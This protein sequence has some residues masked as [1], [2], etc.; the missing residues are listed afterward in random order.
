MADDAPDPTLD[1]L[2]QA[3][4]DGSLS[5]ANIR[6]LYRA[7]QWGGL[8]SHLPNIQPAWMKTAQRY[9]GQGLE[10]AQ[11]YSPEA[12]FLSNFLTHNPALAGTI[13]PFPGPR[14]LAPIKAAG[15]LSSQRPTAMSPSEPTFLPTREPPQELSPTN[16]PP[17]HE[18]IGKGSSGADVYQQKTTLDD[19]MNNRPRI[20]PYSKEFRDMRRQDFNTMYGALDV[21]LLRQ[22]LE[23]VQ[24]MQGQLRAG[25]LPIGDARERQ[26]AEHHLQDRIDSIM[27]AIRN[28]TF[29][30]IPGGKE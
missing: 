21:P 13:I 12:T 29:R 24:Q 17:G 30:S 7:P 10:G 1:M 2:R 14:P 27:G 15:S 5:T 18:Y 26:F 6:D 23:E 8:A 11:N 9:F 3:Y 20:D 16:P 19:V 22:R 28:Q 25:R 4:G